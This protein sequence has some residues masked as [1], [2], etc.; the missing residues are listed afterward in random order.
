MKKG[1]SFK[2]TL[3]KEEIKEHEEILDLIPEEKLGLRFVQR[4]KSSIFYLKDDFLKTFTVREK[5][6]M[7]Y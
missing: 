5:I 6:I 3:S 1:S 4:L 7:D 2:K